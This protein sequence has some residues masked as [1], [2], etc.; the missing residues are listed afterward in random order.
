MANLLA[1]LAVPCDSKTVALLKSINVMASILPSALVTVDV[2]EEPLACFKVCRQM[3][4]FPYFK[5]FSQTFL[6]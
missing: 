4:F 1:T 5:N 6:N 2:S 3:I